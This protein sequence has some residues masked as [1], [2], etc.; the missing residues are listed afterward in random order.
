MKISY[1]WLQDYFKEKLPQSS[2]L[3]ELI[4]A[5]S[6]EIELIEKVGEDTVFDVKVMPDRAHYALCHKGIAREVRAITGMTLTHLNAP[7]AA[8]GAACHKGRICRRVAEENEDTSWG[9]GG[10][11]GTVESKV[12]VS[13]Q[14]KNLCYRYMARRIE[15]VKI[16][17]SPKWLKDRLEAIGARAINSIVDATNYIM[18]DM[19]QPLHAFDADKIKG[20]IVVRKAKKAEKIELL[21]ESVTVDGKLVLKDRSLELTENDLV[22]ADDEGPIA[23]AGVKGGKRAEISNETKNIILESANFN[24]VSIRRTSTRLNIRNDSSKRFENEIIPELAEEAMDRVTDFILELSSGSL[25][26]PTTDECNRKTEKR[27][28]VFTPSF[29]GDKLGESVQKKE[30]KEIL[31][32]VD[33]EITERD[34][35]IVAT[36]PLDRLDMAIPEDIADEVAR[37]KGYDA[38]PSALP[39]ELKEKT[40]QDKTFYWSEKV[41]NILVELGFSEVILYSLAPKGAFDIEYPLASDKAALRESIVPKMQESLKMNAL[42]ADLLGLETIKVFEIGKVFPKSGEKT[43]LTFGVII[44]KKK[45]GVT[46]ESILKETLNEVWAR[47]SLSTEVGHQYGSAAKNKDGGSPR[48]DLGVIELDLDAIAN[49]LP[50]TGSVVD[51]DFKPLPKDKKYQPFSPY[52]FIVRDIALFVPKDESV[53]KVWKVITSRLDEEKIREPRLLSITRFFD[54]FEKDGKNSFAFRIV[55]QSM[56]KTLTDTDANSIMEKIYFEVKR[57]NWEVR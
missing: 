15:N 6:F 7:A 5:H 2:D 50:A 21:P 11:G 44:A 1:N 19:G 14:D 37:I 16:M 48:S 27:D 32:C 3:A 38:M 17:E 18:F 13:I 42:N 52:P 51:L 34:G 26:G 55:L 43:V 22:I 31:E 35:E 47:L 45:K 10:R 39:S 24:P 57:N 41:K 33:C 28:I 20:G 49:A 29:I 56:E 9:R 46:A 36:P 40:P 12:S 30:I 4:N 54:A 25:V 8:P 53:E 23:I